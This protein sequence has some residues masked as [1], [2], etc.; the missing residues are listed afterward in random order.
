MAIRSAPSTLAPSVS[1][2][3]MSANCVWSAISA[4]MPVLLAMNWRSASMPYLPK[5]SWVLARNSARSEALRSLNEMVTL[6]RV[7]GR[8]G[9]AAGAVVGFT[10]AA[11]PAVPAAAAGL[12][13]AAA[14]AMVE[15]DVAAGGAPAPEVAAVGAGGAGA[16]VG[17]G[18]GAACEQAAASSTTV[19]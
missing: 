19:G 6:V 16:A 13:A 15:T 2:P 4:G 14:A 10:A 11:P 9:A 12:A 18:G 3:P 7:A 17:G 8:V 5:R 1:G